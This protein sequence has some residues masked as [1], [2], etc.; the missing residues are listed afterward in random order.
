MFLRLAVLG[1]ISVIC[2]TRAKSERGRLLAVWLPASL[3]GSTLTPLE[4]THFFHEATPAL[5]FGIA[6]RVS[7]FRRR[8]FVAPQAALA[9]VIFAEALLILPAQQTAVMQSRIPP[10]P[11]K[12]NFGYWDLPAY[13]GNWFA[14]ASGA[15]SKSQYEQWFNE[16]G[17]REAESALLRGLARSSSDRLVVLGGQPWLYVESGL[18]PAT[19]YVAVCSSSCIVPSEV[20]DVRHSL[21]SGCADLVVAVGQ[22]PFWQGDLEAGGYVAVEGAPWPTFRSTNPPGQCASG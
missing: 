4:Y 12:H 20:E 15:S 22:L 21:R 10:L 11:L 14:F 13:Y 5:A 16:V 3:A 19:R 6:L 1:A 8:W 17:R 18:L 2:L 7:G 9:L